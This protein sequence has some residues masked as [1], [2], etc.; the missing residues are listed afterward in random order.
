MA[1]PALFNAVHTKHALGSGRVGRL[2]AMMTP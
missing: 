2:T 1:A